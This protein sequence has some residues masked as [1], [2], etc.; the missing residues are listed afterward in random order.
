[1]RKLIYISSFYPEK[2]PG[3]VNKIQGTLEAASR[4][5][6][7]TSWINIV[8]EP[9]FLCKL[10]QAL[11]Q[12]QA[13][14]ILFR[15]IC[16]YNFYLIPAF[17]RAKKR[18][19]KLVMDVPTPNGTAI[20]ELAKSSSSLIRKIKD[21]AYL[22]VS[23]PIPYWFVSRILQYAN[24]SSWFLLGNRSRTQLL[25]NGIEVN[26]IP[27]RNS[28]PKWT[29]DRLDLVCV[30][31]LNYWHGIDRLI[32]AMAQVNSKES[33]LKIFLKVIGEG[34]VFCQLKERV[35]KLGLDSYVNF[36]GFLKGEELYTH[37]ET[38]HLAVGSLALY[39][40]N[41]STASELKSREYCAA[42]LPFIVVG[43]DPDFGKEAKFRIQL[44]NHEP[45]D[46]LVKFFQNFNPDLID[47]SPV[48]IRKYAEKHL[49][50]SVKVRQILD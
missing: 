21:L 6:Y 35:K 46:D 43:N 23:G 10:S 3:V 32:D 26:S 45:I 49:D 12:A 41:L 22:I 11:D 42:G 17:I 2:S 27:I 8:P 50:F 44:A 31:S 36:L 13:E 47:F 29:G 38:A 24:E 40:K 15:S 28:V 37:Y 33:K 30:A 25:G 4:I 19:I 20:K 39:R 18:G 16:Q 5:G 48:E 34:A 9:G 1:M 7:S 14:V